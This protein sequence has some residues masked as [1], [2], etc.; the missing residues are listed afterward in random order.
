M[1]GRLTVVWCLCT[2]R[3]WNGYFRN[4]RT[5]CIK[6]EQWQSLSDSC[7]A[8]VCTWTHLFHLQGLI[9][10]H[11]LRPH[12]HANEPLIIKF[13]SRWQCHAVQSHNAHRWRRQLHGIA[14][15][16]CMQPNTPKT[17]FLTV[18]HRLSANQLFSSVVRVHSDCVT[19]SHQVCTVQ[20][21]LIV[22]LW[23]HTSR[24]HVAS[25][26]LGILR[27][28]LRRIERSATTKVLQPAG[29]CFASSQ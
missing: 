15:F 4:F 23:R 19:L 18:F 10:G 20:P 1:D 16:N 2:T 13:V 8:M 25:S 27:H 17:E 7:C 28:Q 12:F 11:G 14:R 29:D 22:V 26:S 6:C 9:A 21:E 3:C 24:V 5:A